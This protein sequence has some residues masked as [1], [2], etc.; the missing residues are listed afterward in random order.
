MVPWQP[1]A[2]VTDWEIRR[3]PYGRCPSVD[4]AFAS[5]YVIDPPDV[6]G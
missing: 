2:R 3:P 5:N 1:A 4:T 6:T